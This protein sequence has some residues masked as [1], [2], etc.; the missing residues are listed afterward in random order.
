M[1]V[2]PEHGSTLSAGTAAALS[3][4]RRVGSRADAA[5]ALALA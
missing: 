5:G 1:Y 3:P 2:L 4:R